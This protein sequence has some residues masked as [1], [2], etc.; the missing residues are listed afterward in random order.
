MAHD[1]I[2]ED[3]EYSLPCDCGGSIKWAEGL[4]ECDTCDFKAG[5]PPP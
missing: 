5:G 1:D 2:P 3:R 4:W